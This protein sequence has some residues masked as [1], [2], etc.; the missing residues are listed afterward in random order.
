MFDKD[1]SNARDFE[2]PATMFNEVRLKRQDGTLSDMTSGTGFQNN[3]TY[4]ETNEDVDPTPT[5]AMSA[6]EKRRDN[7]RRLRGKS[8]RTGFTTEEL[9]SEFDQ[10][11]MG[12]HYDLIRQ[13]EE[14]SIRFEGLEDNEKLKPLATFADG[15]SGNL[16]EN[17]LKRFPNGPTT[18]QKNVIPYL[19]HSKRDVNCRSPTGSGKT[20]TFL[21]PLIQT[22]HNRKLAEDSYAYSKRNINAPYAVVFS[23]TRELALQLA[24][25]ATRLAV[26]TCVHVAFCVGDLDFSKNLQVI[27]NGTD[28]LVGTVGRIHHIWFGGDDGKFPWMNMTYLVLDEADRLIENAE[29]FTLVKSFKEHMVNQEHRTWL[30]S[31]TTQETRSEEMVV[32][33]PIGIF[34]GSEE[35]PV[36]NVVQM[37]IKINKTIGVTYKYARVDYLIALLNHLT[38]GTS[39]PYKLTPRMIVFVKNKRQSDSIA[40]RL[41]SEGFRAMSI[42]GDRPL[43]SR[44]KVIDQLRSGE[45]DVLV[46]TDVASRGLNI[47]NVDTVFNLALPTQNYISYIHRIGRT[48]RMG[49]VGRAISLFDPE[50][51][52]GIGMFLIKCMK[53][54]HQRPPEWLE[55][56]V[57]QSITNFVAYSVKYHPISDE[58][59]PPQQHTIELD[60]DHK[61]I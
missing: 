9:T 5:P 1:W 10:I 18:V 19:L 26:G 43:D 36:Q 59:L 61:F 22:I 35:A 47:P 20:A 2:I 13:R 29:F 27:R 58:S 4:V 56:A 28:I 46:A 53:S 15:I 52:L 57:D 37:F 40:V 49:N 45:I 17:T 41:I 31:A 3:N 6:A 39:G 14:Q 42:N 25:D 34:V 50:E 44:S 32:E 33:N 60:P 7:A 30:F 51:D 55:E 24:R 23:P 21:L 54:C 38:T 48:G 8:Q 16:L 12:G 11:E